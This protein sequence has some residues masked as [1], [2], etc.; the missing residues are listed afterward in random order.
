MLLIAAMVVLA[1]AETIKTDLWSFDL[2]TC[3]N[4]GPPIQVQ[5][6]VVLYNPYY[7]PYPSA[8]ATCFLYS[9]AGSVSY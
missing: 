8:E 9:T 5:S 1:L 6:R 3:M 7:H 4:G 2:E